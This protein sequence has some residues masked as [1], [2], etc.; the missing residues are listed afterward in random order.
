[1]RRAMGDKETYRL[2]EAIQDYLL[3]MICE[4]YS[5]KTW[6][7]YEKA[8]N[9][10]V[11]FVKQKDR[12]V[13]DILTPEFLESFLEEPGHTSSSKAAIRGL[14]RYLFHH[15]RIE[16]PLKKPIQ[17]LPDAFENYLKY[18]ETSREVAKNKL[19]RIRGVLTAFDDHLQKEKIALSALS[20]EQLDAF[21]EAL[22]QPIKPSTRRVYRSYLRGFLSYLYHERK[23]LRR[24]FAPLLVGPRLFAPTK[25]PKFLRAHELQ[26]LLDWLVSSNQLRTYAMVQL[27]SF[28]GLRPKRS[29]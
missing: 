22:Y 26:R 7:I 11:H 9:S 10:F 15:E 23:I 28:L 1:M 12:A 25:P 27:A 5:H 18:Y 24:D 13:D 14:G 17:P 2:Q 20:I 19:K 3:W 8:L 6:L 29:V 4:G 16:R 21:Q